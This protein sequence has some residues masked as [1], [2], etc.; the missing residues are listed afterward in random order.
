MLK[1]LAQQL[2]RDIFAAFSKVKIHFVHGHGT[3]FCPWSMSTAANGVYA[4]IK[5]RC[6]AV[7]IDF[8]N[9]DLTLEPFMAFHKS[10][11]TLKAEQKQF[12]RSPG[13]S[14]P[15]LA[16]LVAEDDSMSKPESPS[17]ACSMIVLATPLSVIL[18]TPSPTP[19]FTNSI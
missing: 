12:L 10:L 15:N 7:P 9:K 14:R 13:V 1:T 19:T 17:H 18:I 3:A 16:S 6:V 2:F 4:M 11:A 8:H 5:E